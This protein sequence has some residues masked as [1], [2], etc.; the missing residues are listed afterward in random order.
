MCNRIKITILT[1]FIISATLLFAILLTN[2]GENINTY[3]VVRGWYLEGVGSFVNLAELLA[4]A[5]EDIIKTAIHLSLLIVAI[6]T[7]I[8][9]FALTYKSLPQNN[10][11]NLLEKNKT[12]TILIYSLFAIIIAGISIYLT[13]HFSITLSNWIQNYEGNRAR[14]NFIKNVT[15]N[16]AGIFLTL[17]FLASALTPIILSFISIFRSNKYSTS[18]EPAKE[19]SDI[20]KNIL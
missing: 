10:I 18:S 1:I 5:R 20:K 12:K 4:T 11:D 17:A 6:I 2:L 9:S 3:A 8:T 16:T 7:S 19:L 13:V 15:H 14:I